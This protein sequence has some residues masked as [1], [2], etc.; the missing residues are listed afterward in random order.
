MKNYFVF[1]MV[2]CIVVMFFIIPTYSNTCYFTD[3][4]ATGFYNGNRSFKAKCSQGKKTVTCNYR[5]SSKDWICTGP[6]GQK[7]DLTL[8]IAIE[9]A[10]DYK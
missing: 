10:C 4:G 5:D 8:D 1:L 3:S 9:K 2:L 7:Y 6:K